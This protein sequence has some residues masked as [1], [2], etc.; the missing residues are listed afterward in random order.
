M[1]SIWRLSNVLLVLLFLVSTACSAEFLV[2]NQQFIFSESE[3]GF[4]YFD[5]RGDVPSDWMSPDDFYEG[6]WHVRYEIVDYPS[7]RGINLQ[8]CIWSEVEGNWSSWKETCSGYTACSGTGVFTA[9]SSPSEWWTL[10]G[11]PVNFA[12]PDLF[13]NLGIVLRNE[14]TCIISDWGDWCWS[15]RADYLPMR[16]RLTVV[17]VSAG[18]SFSGWEHYVGSTA[19]R[20]RSAWGHTP[21]GESSVPRLRRTADGAWSVDLGS[22]HRRS[23]RVTLLGVN[24]RARYSSEASGGTWRLPREVRPGAYVIEYE[25]DAGTL[26][27]WGIVR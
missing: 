7:S 1:S 17:A 6:Q 25:C 20:P 19:E 23:G 21:D 14:S 16:M 12:R 11:V 5:A 26:R 9:N 22:P 4:H 10:N 15:E 2:A 8:S 18:S 13:H 3:H 27:G 24:G